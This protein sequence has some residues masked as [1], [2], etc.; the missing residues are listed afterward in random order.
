[1]PFLTATAVPPLTEL[2]NAVSKEAKFVA[3]A[4]IAFKLKKTNGK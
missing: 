4:E 2:K 3:L 1:M